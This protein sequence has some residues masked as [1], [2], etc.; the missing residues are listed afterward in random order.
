MGIDTWLE[1]KVVPATR[2]FSMEDYPG[3]TDSVLECLTCESQFE[4]L[5]ITPVEK[6]L[7]PR[8]LSRGVKTLRVIRKIYLQ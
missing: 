3:Y 7:C 6:T 5:H 4:G 8:C 2:R 1:R